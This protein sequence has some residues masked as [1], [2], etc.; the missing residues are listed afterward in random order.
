MQRDGDPPRTMQVKAPTHT[1]QETLLNDK[2]YSNDLLLT[3]YCPF[4]FCID[5]K[6]V[7]I[8]E[9]AF[10]R[11][12]VLISNIINLWLRLRSPALCL[13]YTMEASDKDPNSKRASITDGSRWLQHSTHIL[14]TFSI[15]LA[16]Q[17]LA[18]AAL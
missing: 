7:Q 18:T 4:F 11:L 17:H 1:Q 10:P 13:L 14:R 2:C 6:Q 8:D 16:R 15:Y 3:C 12:N 9:I 5:C